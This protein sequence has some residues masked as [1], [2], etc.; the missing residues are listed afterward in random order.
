MEIYC[1]KGDGI[2][3]KRGKVYEKGDCF[4]LI[5]MYFGCVYRPYCVGG[6]YLDWRYY[7]AGDMRYKK[8]D[9]YRWDYVTPFSGCTLVSKR[10]ARSS[11]D[12]DHLVHGYA[13]AKYGGQTVFNDNLI[14]AHYF[15]TAK[16]TIIKLD[17]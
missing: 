7:S 2:K 17:I 12:P 11:M 1:V 13:T 14:V 3:T 15:D 6:G 10:A 8:I 9:T 4:A 16:S 5:I